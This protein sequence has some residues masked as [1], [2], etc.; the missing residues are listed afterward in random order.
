V[1]TSKI[2]LG[3]IVG[4]PQDV[5]TENE[6]METWF[7]QQLAGPRSSKPSGLGVLVEAQNRSSDHAKEIPVTQVLFY[8]ASTNEVHETPGSDG[9]DFSLKAI[10]L[11]SEVISYLPSPPLSPKKLEDGGLDAQMLPPLDNLRTAAVVKEKKRR[12][13]ADVFDEATER[14]CKARRKGGAS[15]SAAAASRDDEVNVLIGHKKPKAPT[16][17]QGRTANYMPPSKPVHDHNNA[18]SM[19][20][21]RSRT[22]S[23]S[24]QAHESSR[25]VLSRSP[26]MSSENRPTSQMGLLQGTA[27]R[28]S[29]S[30][31]SSLHETASTEDRNKEAISRLVMAGMRLYGLQ[32]QR[33]KT[34]SHARRVSE[35]NFQ[36]PSIDPGAA[37]EEATKDEEYKLIYHQT[38]KGTVFAFVSAPGFV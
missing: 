28:S 6:G 8:A 24:S 13:V 33:K 25:R 3:L 26:S 2:P 14:R 34:T 9:L 18:G 16:K 5:W 20:R 27:K 10:P 23:I 11:C 38:Y 32:Q 12:Q 30:R 19:A 35:N 1:D 22:G 4:P 29:L 15:I 37:Q 31:V 21:P 17:P 36:A 7:A